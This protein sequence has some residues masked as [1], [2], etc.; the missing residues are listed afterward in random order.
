[1]DATSEAADTS[2]DLVVFFVRRATSCAECGADVDNGELLRVENKRALCLACA[3]LDHLEYLPRGDAAL[4]RR[5][6]AHS[7]LYAVVVEWSRTRKRYERQGVLVEPAALEQ[8]EAEC[9]S[10]AEVRARRRVR[11][12]ARRDIEDTTYIAAF[13]SGIQATY[14][15]CPPQEAASIAAH[16]CARYSNRV[17]RSA[18]AKALDPDAILLA[19]QAHVRHA[20]TPYDQLL[21][22][23]ADR[24]RSRDQVRDRVDELLREWQQA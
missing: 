1:M 7:R 19:V 10:D 12:A 4:T 17:G 18:A 23:S 6:R 2:R 21:A 20:H 13:A 24:Q 22:H 5:A 9:L 15:G 16:A 14:P 8:A 11:D 3:D